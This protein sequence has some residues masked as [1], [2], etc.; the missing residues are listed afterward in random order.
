MDP[1]LDLLNLFSRSLSPK[2][3]A[4]LKFLCRD[5]IGKK[6][7]EAVQSGLDLFNI[8]LEQE[9]VTRTKVEFLEHA[10][11]SLQREDLLTLLRQFEDGM[12][13]ATPES[14]DR[15]FE[16]ICD[17][18]GK[19][20]KMLVRKLG[21]S[22]VK[23]DRIVTANPYNMHEQMMQ[24]LLEWRKSRGKEAKVDDVIKALKNCHMKLAADYVEEALAVVSCWVTLGQSHFSEV[25]QP[26]S[27][28]R[29]FVVKE[30]GKGEC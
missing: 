27:P 26:H 4:D 1:F 29:V 24:S 20:W 17:H 16:I 9:I 25:S 23:I 19:N 13:A 15:A 5:R 18:V 7:L 21:I 14:L 22:E 6:K 12:S 30:E 28:H 3:L 2:E 10:F 8:F 11:K